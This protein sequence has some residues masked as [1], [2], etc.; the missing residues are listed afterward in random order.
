MKIIPCLDVKDG[1]VVKGINFEGNKEVGDPVEFAR[2]Y[3]EQGADEIVLYD[4]SAS[5][6]KRLVDLDL[7]RA[8]RE[9]IGALPFTVAGGIDTIANAESVFKAGADKIS[10]N[11]FAI[12]RPDFV[13]RCAE[14]FGS[15]K[16]VIGIDAKRNEAGG[17]HVMFGGGKG[18]DMEETAYSLTEWIRIIEE[19]GAGGI[20]L[21]SV[22]T[23][24]VKNGYDIEMLSA[25]CEMTDIPVIASGG[26]GALPHFSE[27][28]EKTGVAAA[29]AASVFHYGELTVRDVKRHIG[30]LDLV[31]MKEVFDKTPLIPVIVQDVSGEVLMLAYMNYESFCK[32][33]E[34]KTTWF[35]SRSRGEL[36]N[37]GATSGNT[38]KVRGIFLDCD[39]DTLLIRIEQKGNA[40]HTGK[41]SCFFKEMRV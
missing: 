5:I 32:T 21:N 4:I 12:R 1:K 35:W 36:W 25:V 6:N 29:L 2:R 40:C 22:D 33:V 11:S 17:F 14:R 30:V 19:K 13:R 28:F 10:L 9:V 20:C 24:G 8:V 31:I 37:K 23:D 27:V 41:R 15:E 38:Q 16:V 3:A 18:A 7:V 26:C 39:D 34:T